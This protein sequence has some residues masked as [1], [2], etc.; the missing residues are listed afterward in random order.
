M[1]NHL[2]KTY[3]VHSSSSSSLSKKNDWKAKQIGQ[4]DRLDDQVDCEQCNWIRNQNDKHRAL[5][6]NTNTVCKYWFGEIDSLLDTLSCYL[7]THP[8]LW[9][10][11]EKFQ[12][13]AVHH[14]VDWWSNNNKNLQILSDS[15]I[16]FENL[17]SSKNS[18]ATQRMMD[19]GV[20][21]DMSFCVA[22]DV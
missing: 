21:A 22:L 1:T 17:S 2:N 12:W 19:G 7:C 13:K 10:A 4:S 15:F 5:K 20:V 8:H 18:C 14:R 9:M 6:H 3:K 11:N 16:L